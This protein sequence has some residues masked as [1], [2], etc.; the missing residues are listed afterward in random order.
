MPDPRC[1]HA[2]AG[3]TDFRLCVCGLA[4]SECEGGS[5]GE[6]A[7]QAAAHHLRQRSRCPPLCSAEY[8]PCC[9]L[10]YPLALLHSRSRWGRIAVKCPAIF[11]CTQLNATR[12]LRSHCHATHLADSVDPDWRASAGRRLLSSQGDTTRP[13]MEMVRG[14]VFDILQGQL[15]CG[16]RLPDN[17][18]WLDLFAGTGAGASSTPS[19]TALS[20]HAGR[21]PVRLADTAVCTVVSCSAT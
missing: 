10:T 3:C 17:C 11:P 19:R 2:R 7:A 4:A 20:V 13:M 6:K 5:E 8:P 1:A 21:R 16:S 14:A 18:R 15:G 12:G 9:L